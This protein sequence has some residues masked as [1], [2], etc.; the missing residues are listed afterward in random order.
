MFY[1]TYLPFRFLLLPLYQ[2]FDHKLN[3]SLEVFKV[4]F[5]GLA[6]SFPTI[7]IWIYPLSILCLSLLV[8]RKT[9]KQKAM[10]KLPTKIF[11]SIL[12]KACSISAIKSS[13]LS[14]PTEKR[15]RLSF[16]PIVSFISGENVPYIVDSG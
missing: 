2:T 8:L 4:L 11:Q 3:R 14:S 1:I 7:V 5:Q 9:G 12:S 16:I 6:A 13:K 15:I 10:Q